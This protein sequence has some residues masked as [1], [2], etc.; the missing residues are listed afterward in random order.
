MPISRDSEIT[1]LVKKLVLLSSVRKEI[2]AS[3]IQP[4]RFICG[5]LEREMDGKR[6]AAG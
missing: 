5:S 3:F 4:D 1:V 6:W 2:P